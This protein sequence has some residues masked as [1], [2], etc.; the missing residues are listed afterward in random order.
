MNENSCSGK[1][2]ISTSE[3]RNKFEYWAYPFVKTK[4][5]GVFGAQLSD[6]VGGGLTEG[7][8]RTTGVT[9]AEGKL[10]AP[11]PIYCRRH[12]QAGNAV[13]AESKWRP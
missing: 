3:I 10:P 6:C 9:P 12:A 5:E 13:T 8:S 2:R 11:I 4:F 1:I 7:I